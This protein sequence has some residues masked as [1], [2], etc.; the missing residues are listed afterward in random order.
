[1]DFEIEDADYSVGVGP[2]AFYAALSK[3]T[4]HESTCT[5]TDEQIEAIEFEA[6]M[7]IFSE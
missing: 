6:S 4:A 5:L 1:M 3:Y 7:E 2:Q